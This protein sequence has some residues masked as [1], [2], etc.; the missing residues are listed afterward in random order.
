MPL[1]DL[2]IGDLPE[3][4]ER[5][6]YRSYDRQWIVADHRVIDAPKL[7][8]WRARGQR[9]VFL[10]TLTSTKLGRGPALTVTPYVPDLHHFRGSYGA[11]NVIPLYRDPGGRI[12]NVTDGLLTAMGERLGADIS[13]EDLLAYVYAL[14]GTAAFGER[15]ADELAE[16]AGPIHV[17]ITADLALFERA[18]VLGCDL[19]WWHT[20]GERFAPDGQ[21]RLPPG[22]AQPIDPVNTM[23]EQYSYNP[24]T[25]VLTV[26]TGR[27]GP[28]NPKVWS[29]EVSGLKVLHS[30]LG[31]RMKNRKG[32]KSSPLDDIRS[33]RWTQ[34]DELLRLLAILEHTVEVTPTAANLLEA[35][36]S[37]PLIPA[38]ALP[39]PNDTQR[40]PLKIQLAGSLPVKKPSNPSS[41]TIAFSKRFFK[42]VILDPPL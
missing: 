2:V 19:L 42:I 31:Y 27:F 40:K 8:L 21:A 18:V 26:G 10:T 28:V 38:T 7:H 30:W 3:S 4:I 14:G 5:Y 39:D 1:H 9:Q 12:L 13:A 29:F 41:I 15:F 35:I 33:D 16:A 25:Q 11:K 17:P 37:G 20:W 34:T 6:G 36:V 24:D 22:K 32:R 23:P